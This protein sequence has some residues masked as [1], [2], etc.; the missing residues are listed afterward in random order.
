MD[1]KNFVTSIEA[2]AFLRKS[3]FS[4]EINHWGVLRKMSGAFERHE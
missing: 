1:G 4:I 2:R 3:F